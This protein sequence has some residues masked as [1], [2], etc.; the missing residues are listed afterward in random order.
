MGILSAVKN[1]VEDL[2]RE[3][4][5]DQY[6]T[7]SVGIESNVL[8]YMINFFREQQVKNSNKINTKDGNKGG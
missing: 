6:I 8:K 3:G 4:F 2:V 7:K 5:T 1:D